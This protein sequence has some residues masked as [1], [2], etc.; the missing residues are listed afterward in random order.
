MKDSIHER[1]DIIQ[2]F[3]ISRIM[4]YMYRKEDYE[5]Q[6]YRINAQSS[7]LEMIEEEIDAGFPG[8][9]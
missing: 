5:Y 3:Q 8:S 9:E 6:D 7:S 4:P 2:D 1:V